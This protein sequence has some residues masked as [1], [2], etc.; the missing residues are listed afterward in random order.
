MIEI[1]THHPHR[2]KEQTHAYIPQHDKHIKHEKRARGPIQSSH[3]VDEYGETKDV[4]GG[5]GEVD[6][7]LGDPEGR[8][9]VEGKGLVFIY[10]GAAHK[11]GADFGERLEGVEQHGDEQHAAYTTLACGDGG[12]GRGTSSECSGGS[13]R[14]VEEECSD[15]DGDEHG[16]GPTCGKGKPILSFKTELSTI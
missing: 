13:L 3:K 15:E 7:D 1:R 4:E 5:K 11:G 6:P 14:E 9:T 12:G 8:G 10:D 2:P 16:G